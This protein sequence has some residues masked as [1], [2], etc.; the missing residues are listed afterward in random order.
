[1]NNIQRIAKNASVMVISQIICYGLGF[2]YIM[3]TARFLGAEGFGILSLAVA[4]TGIFATFYDAGMSTLAVREVAKD[5]LLAGKYLGNIILMKIIIIPAILILI[6]LVTNVFGYSDQTVKVVYLLALSTI[7]TS[8]S[9]MFNSIFQAY[10]N[11]EYISIGNILNSAS[12][13]V[14]SLI[15]IYL[16]YDVIAFAT[17]Y[18]ITSIIVLGYR[19]AICAQKFVLPKVEVDW[20]FW[21]QAIIEAWPLAVMSTCVIIRFRIDT[22]M[23]SLMSDD[24]AI[25]TYNA[26]YRLLDVITSPSGMII[27]SIFPVMAQYHKNSN[28]AFNMAYII[29]SKFLLIIV[30]PMAL[31]IT[32]LSEPI[33]NLIFGNEYSGSINALRIL[34]WAAVSIYMSSLMGV[35]YVTSNRQRLLMKI[36]I[37]S[38]ILNIIL[39]LILIPRFSYLGASATVV[40]TEF[41]G[42]ISC[43]FFFNK[44]EYKLSLVQTCAPPIFGIIGAVIIILFFAF[45][46]INIFIMLFVSIIIYG[47]II[48]K[49]GITKYDAQLIS[50][51][52]DSPNNRF[53]WRDIKCR[54]RNA[55]LLNYRR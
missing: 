43:I 50:N 48:W 16:K 7:V 39:N 27:A 30:L 38:V 21:K 36:T 42:L 35:I 10:E 45:F 6:I 13:L 54:Y 25:G 31:S 20:E 32:L 34:I 55:R 17:I 1:M 28:R 18:L 51:I 52:L 41:F 46:R 4:F 44:Y 23:L 14:G 11:M 15:A 3:Y 33:I 5:K 26:A 12:M 47:A 49:T 53:S 22:I 24:V 19:F 2:L 29:L 9:G 40:A 8:I 37:I